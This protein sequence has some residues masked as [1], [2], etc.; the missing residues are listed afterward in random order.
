M[1]GGVVVVFGPV[2]IIKVRRY[3]T[4]KLLAL[5]LHWHWHVAGTSLAKRATVYKTEGQRANEREGRGLIS[6]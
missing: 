5:A 4:A 2:V 3:C 6:D 1:L